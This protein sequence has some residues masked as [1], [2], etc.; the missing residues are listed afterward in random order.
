[1]TPNRF[2]KTKP[3]MS[4][5]FHK[6]C[7]F[8]TLIT[9]PT[10]LTHA[11]AAGQPILPAGSPQA[12]SVG[13]PIQKITPKPQ[14][15]DDQQYS[16]VDSTNQA[17][18]DT[19]AKPSKPTGPPIPVPPTVWQQMN[20]MYTDSPTLDNQDIP[21][22]W[23]HDH[24]QWPSGE[25]KATALL[26]QK[27]EYGAETILVMIGVD[28]ECEFPGTAAFT[29]GSVV[30]R[31]DV[32]IDLNSPVTGKRLF[33]K[34]G[35]F[36]WNGQAAPGSATDPRTNSDYSEFDA[37]AQTI[38][39]LTIKNAKPMNSCSVNVAL[40]SQ[41]VQDTTAQPDDTINQSQ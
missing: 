11:A 18:G 27:Y 19:T 30:A 34:R 4:R 13:P 29:K 36:E 39:L 23:Q 16:I 32:F 14:I 33:K 41:T 21:P 35:C 38:D 7:L 9:A 2:S 3:K 5:F 28:D 22:I 37:V 8:L 6:V 17:L 40:P 10:T 12:I 25:P 1:M 26:Y 31:C 15:D 20:M 24:G